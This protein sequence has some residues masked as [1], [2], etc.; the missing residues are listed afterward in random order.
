MFS[1]N[2]QLTFKDESFNT[3]TLVSDFMIV[4]NIKLHE[5]IKKKAKKKSKSPGQRFLYTKTPERN[6]D[7][8]LSGV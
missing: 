8:F 2:R 7:L 5:A 1:E 3:T 6:I 4:N